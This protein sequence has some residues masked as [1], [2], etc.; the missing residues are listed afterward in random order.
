[1]PTDFQPAGRV[2]RRWC[3][4]AISTMNT[5]WTPIDAM[6]CRSFATWLGPATTLQHMALRRGKRTQHSS[7]NNIN[8][9]NNIDDY[10][11][12]DYY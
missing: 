4:S 9:N 11:D 6:T 5:T 7:N 10:C 12:Y 8:N 2:A 3:V 1:M